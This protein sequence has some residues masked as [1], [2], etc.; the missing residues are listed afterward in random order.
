MASLRVHS[1]F[2]LILGG[3]TASALFAAFLLIARVSG[4][5]PP[6]IEDWENPL[7]FSRNTEPPHATLMPYGSMARAVDGDG[8]RSEFCLSLNGPW[9]FFWVAKPADRPRDFFRTDFDASRWHDI[10]VPGNWQFQGYDMPIYL[11]QAYPFPADPPHI[12]HDHNPVGSYRRE[13]TVPESWRGRQVYLHFD[14]VDSVFYALGQRRERR[15][16]PGQPDAG[17]VQHH[18]PPSPGRQRPGGRGLSLF[19]TVRT[20]STRTS[21]G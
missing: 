20:S 10:S 16:Q 15:L 5:A 19:R 18:P 14:G 7:V 8:F 9:K 4:G 2:L 17:R 12:P 6:P 11:N 3:V 1:G 13:F 21:G